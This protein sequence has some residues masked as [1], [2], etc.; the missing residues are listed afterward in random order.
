V[1]VNTTSR[2]VALERWRRAR[3]E[4]LGDPATE[5][6][7]YGFFQ[8]FRPDGR[9]L[10]EVFAGVV[11]GGELLQRL[12]ELYR[13]T[14]W[15]WDPNDA[16]FL[17]KAPQPL[18][19]TEMRRLAQLHHASM[20]HVAEL[21]GATEV[22]SF[23][24]MGSRLAVVAR[25]ESR[26]LAEGANLEVYEA[27]VNFVANLPGTESEALLL[28]EAYYGIACDYFLKYHLLWPLYDQVSP[29]SEP[30]GAYYQLWKHGLRCDFRNR[31]VVTVGAA[32]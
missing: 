25:V 19:E 18:A 14:A 13:V 22:K 31:G 15:G 17:V 6:D 3:E 30:F 4:A 32:A 23:L 7:L 28:G 8:S 29:I 1:S 2:E 11:G 16:Y 9:G 21:A 24:E 27:A 12:L 5:A 20:V 26:A 10:E